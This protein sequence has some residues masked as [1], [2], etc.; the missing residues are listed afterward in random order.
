MSKFTP[1]Q[2]TSQ[3]EDWAAESKAEAQAAMDDLAAD[4]DPFGFCG[5]FGPT[6]DER[7]DDEGWERDDD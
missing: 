2:S 5:S 3:D 4:S 7:A 1:F 6:Q